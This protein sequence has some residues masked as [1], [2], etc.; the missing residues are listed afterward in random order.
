MSLVYFKCENC[1]AKINKFTFSYFLLGPEK[2]CCKKCRSEY[3]MPKFFKILGFFYYPYI[4][5]ILLLSTMD[6]SRYFFI[7]G[8]HSIT[9]ESAIIGYIVFSIVQGFI[10]LLLPQIIIKLG[11]KNGTVN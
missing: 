2:L 11:E 6:F 9:L 1:G 3:D 10:F 7:D 5:I 4:Y 8:K